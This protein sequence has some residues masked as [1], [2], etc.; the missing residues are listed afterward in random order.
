[1]AFFWVVYLDDIMIYSKFKD[2]YITYLRFV[3]GEL[4]KKKLYANLENCFLFFFLCV[5]IVLIFLI[6]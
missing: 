6:L 3:F 5:L 4:Q 2:E 1:M